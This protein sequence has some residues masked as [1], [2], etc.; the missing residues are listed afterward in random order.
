MHLGESRR[1]KEKE[2][3]RS[4]YGGGCCQVEKSQENIDRALMT[5]L[6]VERRMTWE[7]KDGQATWRP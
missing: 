5:A 7:K 3:V 1:W 6:D 4:R 2:K